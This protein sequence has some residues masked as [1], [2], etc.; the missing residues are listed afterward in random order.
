MSIKTRLGK[1]EKTQTNSNKCVCVIGEV[2]ELL[3]ARKLPKVCSNCG[4]QRTD[5]EIEDFAVWRTQA[6]ARRLEVEK[7]VRARM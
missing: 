5:K 2:K 7:Q 3:T 6:D 4:E 1:L